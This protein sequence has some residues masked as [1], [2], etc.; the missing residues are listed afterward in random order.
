MRDFPFVLLGLRIAVKEDTGISPA[1][2]TYGRTLRIPGEFFATNSEI[3][4]ECTYVKELRDAMSKLKP[5]PFRKKIIK[6]F[7]SIQI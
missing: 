1:E 3:S 5:L 4:D 6:V 7:L 2:M